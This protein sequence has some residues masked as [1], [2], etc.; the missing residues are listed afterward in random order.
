MS[1]LKDYREEVKD[2][3]SYFLGYILRKADEMDYEKDVFEEDVLKELNKD[4]NKI[5]YCRL[6]IFE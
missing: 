1:F 4:W 2:T 5:S 6:Q 3:A